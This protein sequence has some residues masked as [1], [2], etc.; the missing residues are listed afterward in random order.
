[1]SELLKRGQLVIAIGNPLGFE[2]H[3]D[4]G[5]GL[6]A[7]PVTARASNGTMTFQIG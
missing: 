2:I 5:R 7:R 1:M 3:G 4:H 6:G